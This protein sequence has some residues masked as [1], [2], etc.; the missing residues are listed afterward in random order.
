MTRFIAVTLV[1]IAVLAPRAGA[2]GDIQK[3]K[4]KKTDADKGTITIT[5]DGKDRDFTVTVQTKIVDQAGQDVGQRLGDSRFK[6]G[7]AVMFK[8]RMSD[9]KNVLVGL[10]LAGAGPQFT[11]PKVDTSGLKPLPE[12]GPGMYQ[13]YQ[14]GFYPGGKNKRPAAHEVAGRALARQ[15]RPLDADGR[16]SADGKIVLLSVGMSNTSQVSMGFAR[17]LAKDTERNPQLVF[18]N[19]AQGGMTAF[20]I[21]DP[22]DGRTGS[23]YWATVDQR[24]QDA[25]VTRTQV[26]A[27]W[28]KEADAG[29]REGFPAYAEKLQ[30]ELAKIVQLLPARFPNC[31][32]VYLSSRTYGGYARTPLNPEPYA[33]E[34][35]FSVKWLI[36]QQLKGD[37]ALNYDPAKG[38]VTAPWLSWGPYLWANGSRKR[39]DGF[40]YDERDFGPDGTHPSASGVAKVAELMLQFFKTDITTR[41]WFVRPG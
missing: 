18:V 24:L 15:V 37:P 4:V 14:G 13:G 41:P 25:G 33:Y 36:E 31:K 29:P 11:Q 30:R 20:A 12:L 5:V 23:K 2:Q 38:K 1:G 39:A 19:G 26:Q 16:P 17:L 6:E 27:I 8:A 22:N 3:G 40:S 7:A 10:K 32:L 34:S 9:G 28:I 35:A 21:Q